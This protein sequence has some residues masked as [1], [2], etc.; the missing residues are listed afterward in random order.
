MVELISAKTSNLKK[1]KKK[2]KEKKGKKVI[3]EGLFWKG[4]SL[5]KEFL[6]MR[7]YVLS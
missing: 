1:K 2:Q 4:V 3:I 6:L 7:E 5:S